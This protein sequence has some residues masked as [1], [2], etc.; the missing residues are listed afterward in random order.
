M[1]KIRKE[2]DLKNWFKKN[3]KK[4]G[5]S[6]IV[7]QDIGIFPDFIMLEK[8]RRV[9]V[10][11]EIKASNF[12]LHKHPLKRVDKVICIKKDINLKVPVVELKK[13]KLI[14]FDKQTPYSLE[15]SIYK[16]FNKEKILTNSEVAKK[17]NINA[18]T[19]NS[20]LTD[21][22]IQGKIRRLKKRGITL[23]IKK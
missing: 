7:R 11:L 18:A 22:L 21:L 8:N 17:L 3:Y 5:F 13:F 2:A 1:I 15:N 12:L 10:E 23:W 19:A 6:K 16:M 9:K 20:K 4:L 14:G